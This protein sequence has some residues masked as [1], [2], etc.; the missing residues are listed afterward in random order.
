LNA[1][2]ATALSPADVLVDFLPLEQPVTDAVP[3]RTAIPA[4]PAINRRRSNLGWVTV[5]SLL[6]CRL[7]PPARRAGR[8][9]VV[10]LS[11]WQ[12]SR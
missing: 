10:V 11:R 6:G 5:R 4:E 1:G 12:R 9:Q 2:R 3:A 7:D 8:G